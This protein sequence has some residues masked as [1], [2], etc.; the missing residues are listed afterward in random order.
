MISEFYERKI[1]VYCLKV[2][3][4]VILLGVEVDGKHECSEVM[5]IGSD[6]MFV[7]ENL[8]QILDKAHKMA[9]DF[10]MS[11]KDDI[12]SGKF[13]ERMKRY[14]R[15][16]DSRDRPPGFRDFDDVRNLTSFE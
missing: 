12:M 16:R 13:T 9:D 8:V 2:D 1:E 6:S 5:P 15:D 7:E 3:V 14:I 10:P 4:E 11:V